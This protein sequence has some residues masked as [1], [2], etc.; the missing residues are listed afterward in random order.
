MPRSN[1]LDVLFPIFPCEDM[2]GAYEPLKG[3][4]NYVI[5]QMHKQY[6][7]E[8]IPDQIGVKLSGDDTMIGKRIHATIEG[9]HDA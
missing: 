5:D 4:L 8:P 6:A 1:E 9:L 3:K 2:I 7:N